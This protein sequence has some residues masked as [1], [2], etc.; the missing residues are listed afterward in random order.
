MDELYSEVRTRFGNVMYIFSTVV[1]LE[2]TSLKRISQT[3]IWLCPSQPPFPLP[4]LPPFRG[5]IQNTV[6]NT[7]A[8]YRAL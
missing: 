1:I 7:P 3:S 2:K 6:H 8:L 5:G 4:L